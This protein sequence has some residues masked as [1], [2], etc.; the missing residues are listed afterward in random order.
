[1]KTPWETGQNILKST[2]GHVIAQLLSTVDFPL[3]NM[4]G[5][6]HHKAEGYLGHR[7]AD[8]LPHKGEV[9]LRHKG[10]AYQ[11]P[12]AVGF[13]LHLAMFTIVISRPGQFILKS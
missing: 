11:H 13:Q 10:E 5:S 9:F 1:M 12:K 8:Y 3:H 4:V 2:D 6:Q 7:V